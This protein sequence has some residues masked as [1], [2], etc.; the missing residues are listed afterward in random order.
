MPTE[1]VVFQSVNPRPALPAISGE[2]RVASFNVLNFFTTID[3]GQDNCGPRGNLGC[4]GADDSQE[5]DRQLEKTVTAHWRSSMRISSGSSR[6]RTTRRIRCRALVAMRS[7]RASARGPTHS[8]TRERSARTRSRWVHLQACGRQPGRRVRGAGQ[9][10]RC[11]FQRFE[12]SPGAGADL[13]AG[14]R[15][16]EPHRGR[17]P[18]Q[19]QGFRAATMSATR[20]STTARATAIR[21]GRMLLWRSSTGWQPT[22]R[23]AATATS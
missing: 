21:R 9:Q 18:S 14:Q 20:T 2:L 1:P 3:N 23:R 4:R 8:S 22:R 5:Y 11:A 13:H 7:M 12:E 6:S 10:C 19:V 17:Q 15:R 16:R